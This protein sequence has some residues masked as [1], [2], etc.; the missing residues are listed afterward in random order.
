M[1][2]RDEPSRVLRVT[3]PLGVQLQ[4][5]SRLEIDEGPAVERP[6]AICFQIGCISEYSV[7]AE[8][9][10]Q[11]KKGQTLAIGATNSLGKPIGL[12]MPLTDLAKADEG[13]ASDPKVFDERRKKLEDEI[14][15]RE[16]A[17][18]KL[19]QQPSTNS[20][21]PSAATK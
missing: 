9:M 6:Y 3:V 11:L 10:G 18:K 4:P 7:D 12:A 19:G 2:P 17:R 14:R 20:R 16:E 8:M 1:E 15:M 5:G 13:P 21:A